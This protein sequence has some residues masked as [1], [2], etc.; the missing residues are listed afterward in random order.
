MAAI[1][2]TA[3]AAAVGAA[4]GRASVA[5]RAMAA[6]AACPGQ[7]AAYGECIRRHAAPPAEVTRG[8]CAAE[9]SA[10]KECVMAQVRAGP[11]LLLLARA[12][13]GR[14]AAAAVIICRR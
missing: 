6:M 3:A 14:A 9:F 8:C 7:V 2:M 5:T 10:M 1:H 11:A 4:G 12:Q 13:F